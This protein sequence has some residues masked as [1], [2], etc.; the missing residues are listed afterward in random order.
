MLI[1]NSL[2]LSIKDNL[3]SKIEKKIKLNLF[4][5]Y[6]LSITQAINDFSKVDKSLKEV[7]KP[8]PSSFEKKCLM[9]IVTI[10][11]L[12]NSYIVTIKEKNLIKDMLKILGDD[13]F[14]K[15]IESTIS[16]SSS[17]PEIINICKL[18]KTSGYRKIGYLVR[19]GLLIERGTELTSK[20]RS[21]ERLTTVFEKINF[22]LNQN[23]KFVRF[24]IP[25]KT[26]EKSSIFQLIQRI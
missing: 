22:E 11:I 26:M 8:D 20:R 4:K 10:K 15:I 19:H 21:I 18:P 23:H 13:E 2:S 7:F 17:V 1:A 14:L 12:N 3:D 25:K 6:G 24:G 16:S 9:Q 5:K